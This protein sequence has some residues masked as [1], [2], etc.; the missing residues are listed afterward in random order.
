VIA[1]QIHRCQIHFI[2]VLGSQRGGFLD[3]EVIHVGPQPVGVR[4]IVVGTGGHQ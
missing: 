3:Q 1:V 2:E 4:D